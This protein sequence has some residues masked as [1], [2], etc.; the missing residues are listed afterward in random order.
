VRHGAARRDAEI[1]RD[2]H[3]ARA[4]EAAD[5]GIVRGSHAVLR[6]AQPELEQDLVRAGSPA[7]PHGVG[8]HEA[9]EVQQIEE[10]RLEELRDS[11]RTLDAHEGHA[12]KGCRAFGQ[13][14]D[15]E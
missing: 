5:I 6:P 12:G 4:V 3:V 14:P 2:L 9:G 7:I 11:E 1:L 13:R 8:R 10:R 15:L